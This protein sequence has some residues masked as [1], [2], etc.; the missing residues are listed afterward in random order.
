MEQKLEQRAVTLAQNI[1]AEFRRWA[2]HLKSEPTLS[3][4]KNQG[5]SN[6]TFRLDAEHESWALRIHRASTPLGVD[7]TRERRIH[8]L[9]AR[10][11]LAPEIVHSGPEFLITPWLCTEA[12]AALEGNPELLMGF[13]RSLHSL[14]PA[15]S[16][17]G[18]VLKVASRLVEYRSLLPESSAA[19]TKLEENTS[20]LERAALQVGRASEEGSAELRL[21]HN[22]LN[23]TNL[24]IAKKEPVLIDGQNGNRFTRI[25]K[26]EAVRSELRIIALDWEY[27]SIGHPFHDLAVALLPFAFTSK[28]QLLSL[29]LGQ[30]PNGSELERFTSFQLLARALD[31]CWYQLY[32]ALA[33]LRESVRQFELAIHEWTEYQ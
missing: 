5:S 1:S 28:I 25:T 20:Y 16:E 24:R 17:P 15:E 6:H 23:L 19:A 21:C 7:R 14:D 27:A 12:T 31:L 9:A 22:D 10:R 11:G 26:D 4:A 18:D 8:S 3:L 30:A 2:P 33:E 32:G 29:Y 13:L